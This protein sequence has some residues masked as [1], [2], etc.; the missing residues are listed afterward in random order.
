MEYEVYK[1]IHI[2]SIIVFFGVMG[3]SVLAGKYQ[4][5]EKIVVGLS[6]FFILFGGMGLVAR[7]GIDHGSLWPTW[8]LVKVFMWLLLAILVPL[9]A[10]R[11]PA[12]LKSFYLMIILASVAVYVAINKPF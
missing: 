1:F 3:A 8:L 5:H 6:S 10:K 2:V 12:S 11:L 9:I 4:K 7:I